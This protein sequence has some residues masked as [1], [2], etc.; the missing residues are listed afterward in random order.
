MSKLSFRLAVG[1]LGL[2]AGGLAAVALAQDKTASAP[3]EATAAKVDDGVVITPRKSRVLKS[4]KQEPGAKAAAAPA[5]DEAPPK[6]EGDADWG[7]VRKALDE[8]RDQDARVQRET[9]A[10]ELTRPLSAEEREKMRPMGLR[11]VSAGQ[12]KTAWSS[13]VRQ[14]RVPVL[15]PITAETIGP[16]KIACRKNSF[17]AFGELPDGAYFEMIGTRMR[18]V[19]GGPRTRAMRARSREGTMPRLAALKAPYEISH[20]EQGVDLSF[21]RFNIAYQISVLCDDVV[22]DK[23]CAGDEYVTSLADNVAL[24]NQ[25][26]G[27]GK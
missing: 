21:S 19:G 23:R 10:L 27:E 18:V 20:H 12:Y 6:V 4:M 11:A 22:K 13:E 3:A 9:R 8:M 7:D 25:E 26:E 5:Q 1:A 14:T 17:T 15:A 2:A 16:M 24:L